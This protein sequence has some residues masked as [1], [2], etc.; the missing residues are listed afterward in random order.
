MSTKTKLLAELLKKSAPVGALAASDD[1]E[2]GVISKGGRKLIEAWHGS[3]HKFDKFSMDNIGTGEGAQAYGHG[4]YFADEFDVAKGYQPRSYDA[5][6]VMLARYK[7]A[8][9]AE[10]YE[11]MEIW[12]AA[13]QHETPNEILSRYNSGEYGDEF[14]GK[15]QAVADELRELPSRGSLSRVHL[16]VDPDTLLDWDKPLSEQSE[17]VQNAV[18]SSYTKSNLDGMTDDEF[19]SVMQNI[20]SN[21]VYSRDAQMAEFGSVTSKDDI[22]ADMA[23]Y[24]PEGLAELK[25]YLEGDIDMSRSGASLYKQGTAQ[26][27]GGNVYTNNSQAELSAALNKQGIPGIRYKDGMSRGADGGTSN[28]VM[29]D[30]KPISIVERG[31]ADPRLLAGTA[32]ATGLMAKLIRD[33]QDDSTVR[34]PKNPKTAMLATML[35]DGE[36]AVKGSPAEFVYPSGLA[37]WLERLAYNEDPSKL[38]TAMAIADF[39]P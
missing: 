38:E 11:T 3:P 24:N 21:G 9:R 22:L 32:G 35:R 2:A 25:D 16:D 15:A 20:D 31:F 14:A 6:E 33:S 36:R 4:L 5:E 23:E 30:D 26:R 27:G 34:A 13:M 18:R 7:A 28:Y 17:A 12:E 37:P 8:E 1:S 39:L 29:F 10:D 19:Y